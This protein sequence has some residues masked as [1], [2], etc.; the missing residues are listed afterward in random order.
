VPTTRE[1]S[2]V[3]VVAVDRDAG[4]RYASWLEPGHEV[5][6]VSDAA[7]EATPGAGVA[8]VA[9]DDP[10]PAAAARQRRRTGAS[11]ALLV[12]DRRP[13]FDAVD[14]GYDDLLV[15]PSS[16]AVL[17]ESV[18]ELVRRERYADGV[19]E[20]YELARRRAAVESEGRTDAAA[21]LD[22]RLRRLRE[23]LDATLDDLAADADFADIYL[24]LE[25]ASATRDDA[26]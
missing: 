4:R 12:V 24:D 3:V 18:A 14:A 1:S 22:E 17:R 6:R 26:P 9:A 21:E 5:R 15:E 25:R 8:V 11:R 19:R 10:E 2:P 7:A 13:G 16:A 23:R 20:L